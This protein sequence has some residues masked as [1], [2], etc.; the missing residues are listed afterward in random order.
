MKNTASNGPPERPV[1]VPDQMRLHQLLQQLETRRQR[2]G[3]REDLSP[4][5]IRKHQRQLILGLALAGIIIAAQA[6]TVVW[7]YQRAELL[8]G[9]PLSPALLLTA[10]AGDI[11][12]TFRP[13]AS[14]GDVAVLLRELDLQVVD[15]PDMGSRYVLRPEQNKDSK[16]DLNALRDRRDLVY[17][18]DAAY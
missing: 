2:S 3:G 17:S 15:G 18:A 6:T 12:V 1:A 16:R 10:A 14:A 7:L 9:R 4:E 5:A 11:D 13:S 8:L